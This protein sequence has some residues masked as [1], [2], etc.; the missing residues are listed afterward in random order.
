M[1][2]AAKIVTILATK[3]NLKDLSQLQLH[4]PS[5]PAQLLPYTQILQQLT[6]SLTSTI[7]HPPNLQALLHSQLPTIQQILNYSL[8]TLMGLAAEKRISG[9]IVEGIVGVLEVVEGIG[10]RGLKGEILGVVYGVL[11]AVGEM[12]GC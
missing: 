8:A 11:G 3:G 12:W 10:R 7:T 5:T 4:P 1:G 6:H 2:L 9:D